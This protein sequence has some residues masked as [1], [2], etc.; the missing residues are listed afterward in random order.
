MYSFD[1]NIIQ[2]NKEFNKSLKNVTQMRVKSCCAI[3]FLTKTS[4]KTFKY[5]E[6]AQSLVSFPVYRI[7]HHIYNAYQLLFISRWSLSM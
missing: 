7:F 4:L 5:D 1:L 6:Y 3:S 2:H